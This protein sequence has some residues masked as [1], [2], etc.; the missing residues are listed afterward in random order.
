MTRKGIMSLE[1]NEARASD[2]INQDIV[3]ANKEYLDANLRHIE[4]T[5]EIESLDGDI[6]QAEQV[7]DT[8]EGVNEA[9]TSEGDQEVELTSN[10]VNIAVEHLIKSIG[11]KPART[12]AMESFNQNKRFAL[13]ENKGVIERIWEAIKA[14][15]RKL[16]DWFKQAAIFI[17]NM[18]FA[19]DKKEK[20]L[21]EKIKDLKKEH[22]SSELNKVDEI[23]EKVVH[24]T[25]IFKN[26]EVVASSESP[27]YQK[28]K[29][30]S[31]SENTSQAASNIQEEKPKEEKSK[32]QEIE[33]FLGFVAIRDSKLANYFGSMTA[34]GK[35]WSSITKRIDDFYSFK[36][37]AYSIVLPNIVK[38]SDIHPSSVIGTY[39]FVERKLK[40]YNEELKNL[41][42]VKARSI[43]P[44]ENFVEGKEVSLDM[45]LG[46]I[47]TL[48]LETMSVAISTHEYAELSE[49]DLVQIC[50]TNKL[51]FIQKTFR[52]NVSKH[53]EGFVLA[54]E[55]EQGDEALF[56][57]ME[58]L[59]EGLDEDLA[60][61]AKD[62]ARGEDVLHSSEK[63]LEMYK[64]ISI[65]MRKLKQSQY[66]LIVELAR[67]E[68][69]LRNNVSEWL[70]KSAHMAE[71]L[72][73]INKKK[74]T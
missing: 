53:K 26:N 36:H 54:N 37:L 6:R 46:K 34:S 30:H 45:C 2:E 73:E 20:L 19:V 7:A 62:V 59:K 5:R 16:F 29:D 18:F 17:K 22:S 64:N 14:A 27:E 28:L 48:D 13:E 41:F 70:L 31:K 71:R 24:E 42:L 32:E 43:Y 68:A 9:L 3:D 56:T 10:A 51:E 4:Q 55:I 72:A 39:P 50:P 11:G 25:K 61:N 63:Y 40:K 35:L 74:A 44:R 65:N 1:D 52:D 60:L 21:D 67:V 69:G 38:S 12:F 8:L 57:K 66:Y 58:Q 15:F 47:I 33:E 49:N 23:V